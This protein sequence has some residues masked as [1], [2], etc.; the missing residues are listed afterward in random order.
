MGA[1]N[2]HFRQKKFEATV[3]NKLSVHAVLAWKRL[4]TTYIP[5]WQPTMPCYTVAKMVF[6][7]DEVLRIFMKNH[8]KIGKI[9]RVLRISSVQTEK[10]GLEL[11]KNRSTTIIQSIGAYSATY[12]EICGES[13]FDRSIISKSVLGFLPSSYE[14]SNWPSSKTEKYLRPHYKTYSR[15]IMHRSWA[16]S[17]N[18]TKI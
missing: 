18:Y 10:S 16:Y 11:S 3:K 15:M 4:F 9:L 8:C 2:H 14:T 6:L 12:S 5:H 7:A 17:R 13:K 1:K